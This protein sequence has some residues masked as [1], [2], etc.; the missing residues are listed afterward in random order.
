MLP[1][2][3]GRYR[4]PCAEFCVVFC[5]AFKMLFERVSK[6]FWKKEMHQFAKG[7]EKC[8]LVSSVCGDQEAVG[9]CLWIQGV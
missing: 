4:F 3:L 8:F 1:P 6:E 7:F 5:N 9:L 2:N